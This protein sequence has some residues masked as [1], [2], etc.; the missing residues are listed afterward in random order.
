MVNIK[1]P[2]APAW[3]VTLRPALPSRIKR[4]IGGALI[5]AALT[6]SLTSSAAARWVSE[7]LS[8]ERITTD[9]SRWFSFSIS[10][11]SLPAGIDVG[12]LLTTKPAGTL[13]ALMANGEHF[14][15]EKAPLSPVRIWGVNFTKARAFPDKSRAPA[16]A[17]HL[18]RIGVNFVRLHHVTAYLLDRNADD[19]QHFDAAKLDRLDYFI[20]QLIAQGIYID[21]NPLT[22]LWDTYKPGDHIE[23]YASLNKGNRAAYFFGPGLIARQKNIIRTMLTHR[24]PYTKRTYAEEPAFAIIEL[25]NESSFFGSGETGEKSRMP[26][27]YTDLLNRVFV[28]WVQEK[29]PAKDRLLAAWGKL[30]ADEDYARGKLKQIAVRTSAKYSAAR[31]EDTAL[32]YIWIEESYYKSMMAFIRGLGFKGLI[33]GTNNWYGLPA[34]KSQ[35]V[36]DY[37]DINGYQNQNMATGQ[38]E[39]RFDKQNFRVVQYAAVNYQEGYDTANTIE[40]YNCTPFLKWQ[41]GGVA[42]KPLI[43]SEWNWKAAGYFNSEGPVLIAA[44]GSLQ[45]LSG[46]FEFEYDNVASRSHGFNSLSEPT[47]AQFPMAAIAFRRG[48]VSVARETVTFDVTD[49]D[50]ALSYATTGARAYSFFQ[51]PD[52]PR[53]LSAV[54]KVRKQFITDGALKRPHDYVRLLAETRNPVKSDTGEIVWDVND[55]SNGIITVDAPKLQAVVGYFAGRTVALANITITSTNLQSVSLM[56]IDDL[57]LGQSKDMLL[58]VAGRMEY[59]GQVWRAQYKS[60]WNWGQ[61]P[62]LFELVRDNIRLVNANQRIS[63]KAINEHGQVSGPVAVATQG[64][65]HSFTVGNER[66]LWYR[67]TAE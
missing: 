1:K 47:L 48:Y 25:I 55:H 46:F 16:I 30:D 42:G 63:V 5:I 60:L 51:T 36:C 32:F 65:T 58:T 33:N 20:A 62:A 54:H 64:A 29:Y 23:D 22:D 15:F 34:V 9:Q 59:T 7:K 37:M 56:S 44:Y 3:R 6:C 38:S 39:N 17:R 28:Q 10:M 12:A 57:P 40:W 8:D 66:T 2:P 49:S 45:D 52:V 11:D 24:N 53:A 31:V 19:T 67:I 21:Y 4:L 50:T 27:F 14:C 13:G 18:A 61:S 35:L 43:S 41:L 26:K